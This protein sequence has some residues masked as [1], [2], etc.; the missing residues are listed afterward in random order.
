MEDLDIIPDLRAHNKGKQKSYEAFWS[1]CEQ[2]LNEE[3]GVAV[4]DRR[5][6]LVNIWHQQ[7]LFVTCGKDQRLCVQMEQQFQARNGYA[8]SFGQQITMPIH[9][10][11]IQA[12][13]R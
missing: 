7:C 1:A 8:F 3:I 9:P 5:H 13:L 11:N 2:V 10:S 4:D 6:D 12:V